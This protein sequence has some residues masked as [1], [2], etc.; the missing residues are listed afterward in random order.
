MYRI[1]TLR[2]L[3][4]ATTARSLH[5]TQ[6]RPFWQKLK[7]NMNQAA[8]SDARLKKAQEE[9]RKALQEGLKASAPAHSAPNYSNPPNR[10]VEGP[11]PMKII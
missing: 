5:S 9:S 1:P 11:K 8:E 7:E 6:P 2:T 3:T 10:N 4:R